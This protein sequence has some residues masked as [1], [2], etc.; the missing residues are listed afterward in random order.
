MS[1]IA[2]SLMAAAKTEIGEVK[3][4]KWDTNKNK[5]DKFRATNKKGKQ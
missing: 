3:K 5:R 2:A 4:D 1:I